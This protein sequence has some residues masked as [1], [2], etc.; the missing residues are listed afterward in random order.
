MK[1]FFKPAKI[2]FYILM[3]ITFFI[4]GLYFAGLIGAGKGQGLAGGA[5]V[6]G[7]GVLFGGIAF[8]ASFFIA[9]FV[10]HKFIVNAN[11]VLLV[12]IIISYGITH[13]RYKQRQKEKDKTEQFQSIPTTP[14]KQ[15][16]PIGMVTY[17]KNDASNY[18]SIKNSLNV[19]NDLGIGF[20]KPNFFQ[21]PT[22]FFYGN[23][24]QEKSVFQH[25]PTDSLALGR[26][27][28]GDFALISAP[29]WLWPE[30]MNTSFGIFY[31][32]VKTL[33]REFIEV[34]V[35]SKTGQTSYLNKHN[36][37]LLF[38]AEFLLTASSLNFIEGKTQIPKE[39]PLDYAGDINT[40]FV[41]LTPLQVKE[42]W[43][44]VILKDKNYRELGKGWIRWKMNDQLVVKYQLPNI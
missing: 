29:P 31:F 10:S 11:I 13:Y 43:I 24:T 22:L 41:H 3:L 7:Y 26:D 6:L 44:Q 14:T 39:K 12:I 36:G 23:V 1:N 25:T 30:A 21:F 34:E 37:E 40:P 35:N 17:Y 28:F 15:T 9:Y 20:F 8:I 5:I 42:D 27:Q 38:W 4:A 2:A 32:K 33:G 19:N 18:T 16:E